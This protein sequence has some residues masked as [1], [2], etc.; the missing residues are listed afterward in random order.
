[1]D[2]ALRELQAE[3]N[4][5]R[6]TANASAEAPRIL[7]KEDCL[8]LFRATGVPPPGPLWGVYRWAADL[9]TALFNF[10]WENKDYSVLNAYDCS[11]PPSYDPARPQ[12]FHPP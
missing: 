9:G 11:L 10:D 4:L 12:V 5:A 8:V 3:R 7:T 6:I 1:M 2:E